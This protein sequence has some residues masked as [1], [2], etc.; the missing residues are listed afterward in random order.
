MDIVKT[1]NPSNLEIE[2]AP[3]TFDAKGR[4]LDPNDESIKARYLLNDIYCSAWL[5]HAISALCQYKVPDYVSA[6]PT[7]I[8]VI[9]SKVKLHPPTLYRAMRALAANGIFEEPSEGLFA[10]NHVS[11]LLCSEHP[12]SWSGMARMWDH[13]SCV[14]AWLHHR[15]SL[16]DGQSGI[17]HAFGKTLYEHLGDDLRAT[18]AFSDAMVSNSAHASVSIAREFKFNRYKQ[19]MDLGGGAGTLLQTILIENEHLEGIIFDLP[20]L[21]AVA[22]AALLD[23]ELASRCKFVSGDFRAEIPEGAD[24]YLIKNSLWNWND[25]DCIAI[26]KNV[27]KAIGTNNGAHFLL[28]EYVISSEN[29]NWTT[30]YDLQ[31]LNMPGGRARTE[32]EYKKLFLEA[33]LALTQIEIIED[34]TLMLCSPVN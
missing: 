10:H 29:R 31:I 1:G 9:A 12:Y 7:S 2:K 14:Q 8:D 27:R 16:K 11:R 33:G 3:W 21:E 17:K 19:V 26:L 4:R 25:T 20:E 13:P 18:K 23:A 22:K 5:S 28:I 32:D 24:L 6:K 34:Q 15:D 30:A